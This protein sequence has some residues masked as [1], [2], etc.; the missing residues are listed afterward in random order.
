MHPEI[1]RFMVIAHAQME[2]HLL[3][4]S[5]TQCVRI[6]TGPAVGSVH[7]PRGIIV[8]RHIRDF[9]QVEAM[10]PRGGGGVVFEDDAARV[11]F[12]GGEGAVAEPEEVPVVAVGGVWDVVG[13]GVEEPLGAG[14]EVEEL[15][16]EGDVPVGVV[17]E[18]EGGGEAVVYDAVG[19]GVSGWR[20]KDS[21]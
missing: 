5:V 8:V 2:Q 19:E 4:S 20:K 6:Q 3:R 12:D 14:G 17:F 16:P 21:R 15:G 18:D 11:R 13:R 1:D 9:A 10:D 7:D